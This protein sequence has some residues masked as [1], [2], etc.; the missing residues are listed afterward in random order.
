MKAI[1]TGSSGF[2]GS[3]LVEKLLENQFEVLGIDPV[4]N[5]ISNNRYRHHAGYSET[6]S[7]SLV[8]KYFDEN[9]VLFHLGALKHRDSV[10]NYEDMLYSNVVDLQNILKLCRDYKISKLFFSSSLYVYGLKNEPR[11]ADD[12]SS[13]LAPESLYGI[14]KLL[15]EQMIQTFSK[16]HNISCSILRLFFVY[17]PNQYTEKS[18][19]DSLIHKT[20]KSIKSKKQPEIYGSGKQSM[21]FIYIDDLC[22]FLVSQCSNNDIKLDIFNF[23]SGKYYSVEEIVKKLLNHTKS[24][25]EPIFAEAD[26]TEGLQRY[27]TNEILKNQKNFNEFT[28]IDNGLLKCLNQYE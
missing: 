19:Y 17:G 24:D 13:F 5:N 23:S 4:Q 1:V 10:Q 11:Y 15:G 22:N 28:S 12:G 7:N 20:I 26:W 2:I 25:L 21:D 27:G 3:R 16:K 9:S 18:N 6:L 8:K 14:T